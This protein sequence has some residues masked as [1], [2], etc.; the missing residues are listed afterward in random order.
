MAFSP[1]NIIGCFLK[2]GLQRGGGGGGGTDT[3]EPPLTTP[4]VLN[5]L[6][7]FIQRS[8]FFGFELVNNFGFGSIQLI[9]P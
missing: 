3:P 6:C 9:L 4:L 8:D 7:P 2:K 5:S 1:R